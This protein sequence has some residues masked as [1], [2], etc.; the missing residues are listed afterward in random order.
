MHKSCC[1]SRHFS[2]S[3]Q[4]TNITSIVLPPR[5]NLH[6]DSDKTRST[7]CSRKL[8]SM[9]L[10]STLNATES[11]EMQRLLPYSARS[12]FCLYARIMLAFF[13]CCGRHLADQQSMIKLCSLLCKAHPPYLMTSAGMLTGP[14]VLLTLRLIIAFS[15]SSK[16]GGSSNFGMNG[17]VGRSCRKPGSMVRIFFSWLSRYSVYLMRINSLFIIRILSIHL[18]VC[19]ER[20]FGQ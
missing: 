16:D 9:I 20:R 18:A 3:C 4:A 5:R 8:V 17:I 13:H 2:C 14:A 6:L 10:A 15:T 7:T 12:P 11:R 1:S 19:K